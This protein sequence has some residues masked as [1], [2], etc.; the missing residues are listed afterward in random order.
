MSGLIKSF[1]EVIEMSKTNVKKGKRFRSCVECVYLWRKYHLSREEYF[2]FG[3]VNLTRDQQNTYVRDYEVMNDL[4]IFNDKTQSDFLNY[5]DKFD[6]LF[7]DL[8]GREF[9]VISSTDFYK[10]CDFV[11]RHSTFMKK[12]LGLMGGSGIEKINS[13]GK[14]MSELFDEI[15]SEGPVLLE[16]VFV[17]CK[18]ISE[19]NPDTVNTIRVITMRDKNGQIH[20]PFAN[21]RIGRKGMCVDNFCSGGMT[22]GIDVET[23]KV[24]SAAIDGH[25][26]EYTYHPDTNL[27]IKGFE[28]PEWEKV[29]ITVKEAAE[30]LPGCRYIGWDIVISNEN[31]I[32]FIEG[33][34]NP[35]ARIHQLVKKSGLRETYN[36][37]LIQ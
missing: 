35:E 5:K 16:E 13:D 12:P 6:E 18:E 33:N 27:K 21:I 14:E 17:Q 20:V 2:Q 19:L 4:Q 34:S 29:L 24:F 11:N 28:V 37:Y 3:F 23:G 36:K 15:T 8:L 31:K 9:C 10:F 32:C 26:N 30:R 25:M 7:S 1:L 22:A